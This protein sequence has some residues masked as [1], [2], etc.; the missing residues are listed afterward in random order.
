MLRE[1]LTPQLVTTRLA[2]HDK[3]TIIESLI[4]LLEAGGRVRDAK[5]ALADVLAHE[6]DT[7]TGMENGIAIPHAKT[8]AVEA[9]VACVG[10]SQTPVE[11]EC[12]DRKPAR[13]FV[14]TL[15]PR[16]GTGPHV[17][18]LADVARLLKDKKIRKRVTAARDDAE[19]FSILTT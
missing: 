3:L 12:L 1:V 15:S 17:R 13:I 6:R 2:G 8:D 4:G 7:G 16:D 19:L 14:M 11:F 18:F 10:V 5:L 9:L